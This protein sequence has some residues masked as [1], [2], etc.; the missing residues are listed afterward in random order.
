M[1]R[2]DLNALPAKRVGGEPDDEVEHFFVCGHCGQA[3]DYRRLGD[4][5]WHDQ[6]EHEPLARDA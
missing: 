6:P 2:K 5:L 4:V 3:V 1:N